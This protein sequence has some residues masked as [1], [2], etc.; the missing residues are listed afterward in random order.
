[1]PETKSFPALKFPATQ[2]ARLGNGME[3]V[4][5]ERHETPVVQLSMEFP[6]GFSAD[7]GRKLGTANFALAMLDEGA[8]EYGA[9][10][11]SGRKEALGAELSSNASLDTASVS[12][13]ALTDKLAPSL[14]LLADVVLRPRFE[15][16]EIERVRAQWLAGIKQ[17]KARPQT[18]ALRVLPPLLYGEGHAYAIPFTGTGTEASIA[19]LTRDDL[20]A[21]HGDWLQPDRARVF[22]TGDTTLKQILPLLEQRFGGWKAKADAPALP[23]LAEVAR[24]KAPRVFLIDQPGAIQSNLYVGELI[25]PTGDPG[26]IDFDFANGV[27][28]GE[29]SSRLNMNLREDKH[30]AYGS[31]SGAGNA[32][33]QRP[34]IAQAAVQADKTVES[35]G[36]LKREIDAFADGS[37]PVTP[38]EVAKV[39]AA[40]TLSLPGAYETNAAVMLQVS[41]N[42]RYGRPDD[43]VLQ[44]KARND[45]MTPALVQTAAKH[46]DPAALT[47]VV[48]GDLSKIEQPVRALKLGEVQVLDGD[49]KK[50]R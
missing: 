12:L 48:V 6:G 41:S 9:L 2:T 24:P 1:M 20:V 45:A 14:D 5:V 7:L 38:A 31:Y 4:L 27:L 42:R 21:F 43:Y 28:G 29:F 50:I 36:E 15:D 33:G 32:K 47:W 46:L 39:R 16:G 22:V 18:A 8:G 44:F 34:W 26:T 11:L 40:N 13:S 35:L 25:A 49:G 23:N 30:W 37:R 3:V 19:S 17:E 10:Q